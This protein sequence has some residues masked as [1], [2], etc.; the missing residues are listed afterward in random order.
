MFAGGA[1]NPGDVET[2]LWAMYGVTDDSGRRTVGSAEA[3]YPLKLLLTIGAVDELENGLFE[4]NMVEQTL[5]R[6][7][8]RDI[9]SGLA[10][11]ACGE[12]SWVTNAAALITV[13]ADIPRACQHFAAQRPY[14][15]RGERYTYLEAGAAAQNGQLAAAALG[16][17]SVIVAGFEDEATADCLDLNAPWT[18]VLHLCLGLPENDVG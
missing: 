7:N 10:E 12:Q 6:L 13:C 15:L 3:L 17:S 8:R 16:L 5:S 18:P 9:R 2:V 14:G 4:V 11:A 1:L